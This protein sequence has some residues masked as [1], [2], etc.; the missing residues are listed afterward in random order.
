MIPLPLAAYTNTAPSVLLLGP[1]GAGKSPLGD[2]LAKRGL[3]GHRCHHLD[4]GAEL[5]SVASIGSSHEFFDHEELSFI[6]GVL[7]QGLLLE[8]EHFSLAGKIISLFLS[9]NRFSSRDLLVLN[10]IPRHIG[11]AESLA[12]FVHVHALIVLDCPLESVYC[13]ISEN[14]GGDRTGRNDDN[15][16]MISKK[17]KLFRQ[18]TE[19]LIEYYALRQ[20]RIYRVSVS[21]AMTPE[22]T[23]QTVS[24][25]AAAHPPLTLVAEPPER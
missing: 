20:C 10:G 7:E 1:T 15:R 6:R 19:P 9:H 23:Y 14:A 12:S 11:Q 22:Q 24:V 13:R 25:L 16:E 4:F 8:N 17:L 21:G 18:R 5:R 2:I 3:L